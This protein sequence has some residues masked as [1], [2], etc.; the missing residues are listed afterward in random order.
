MGK[1]TC[2]SPLTGCMWHLSAKSNTSFPFFFFQ[3]QAAWWHFP[4]A[5]M[6]VFTIQ[7][8]VCA[9]VLKRLSVQKHHQAIG[10]PFQ[11]FRQTAVHLFSLREREKTLFPGAK[12][13][14]SA[15]S[16]NVLHHNFTVIKISQLIC[17]LALLHVIILNEQKLPFY[18]ILYW[19]LEWFLRVCKMFKMLNINKIWLNIKATKTCHHSGQG[20]MNSGKIVLHIQVAILGFNIFLYPLNSFWIPSDFSSEFH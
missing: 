17:R 5:F 14:A 13:H 6:L 3:I 10:S 19:T 9:P 4:E 7:L 20:H 12:L 1:V 11:G 15:S 18:C 8:G 16:P 2:C